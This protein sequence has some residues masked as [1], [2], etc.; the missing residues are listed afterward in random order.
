MKKTTFLLF[1]LLI[2][3]NIDVNAQN[4]YTES[5]VVKKRDAQ[6]IMK[7]GS[8]I[9]GKVKKFQTKPTFDKVNPLSLILSMFDPNYPNYA[10]AFT[11]VDLKKINIKPNGNKKFTEIDI[12]EVSGVVTY[13]PRKNKEVEKVLYKAFSGENFYGKKKKKLQKIVLPIAT[14]GKAINTYATVYPLRKL[15]YIGPF[16]FETGTPNAAGIVHIENKEKNLILSAHYINKEK[17]YSKRKAERRSK[18]DNNKNHNTLNELFGD[19]PETK[20]LIDNFYI[21]RIENKSERKIAAKNYNKKLRENVR[22]FKKIIAKDRKSATSKLYLD[23]YLFDIKEIITT[24]EKNCL[25]IDEFDSR[26]KDY[27]PEFDLNIR[28]E[29]NTI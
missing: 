7:D 4:T 21:K 26:H 8:V 27:K 12:E 24:Y 17:K 29:E 2:F 22:L 11:P 25:P 15:F 3:C 23:L 16:I 28:D 20:K 6:V 19:C 10:L 5:T 14:E 1:L 18:R 9:T 13:E